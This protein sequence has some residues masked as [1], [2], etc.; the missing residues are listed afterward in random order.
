MSFTTLFAKKYLPFHEKA[1][2]KKWEELDSGIKDTILSLI[3]LSGLGFLIVALLLTVFPIICHF[4]P[5]IL[6]AIAVPILSIVFCFGLFFINLRLYK[7]TKANTPWQNS[8]IAMTAI[9]VSFVLS[10]FSL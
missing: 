7:K 4:H 2:G 1:A 9:A 6:L 5:D 10:L 3:H 8:F